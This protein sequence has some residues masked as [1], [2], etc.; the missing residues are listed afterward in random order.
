MLSVN[1]SHAKR[2]EHIKKKAEYLDTDKF[3]EMTFVRKKI[4]AKTTTEGVMT[5][6]LTMHGVAKEM[7]FVF[8]VLG[9]GQDP[10]GGNRAGFEAHTALK[11][12]DFGFAWPLKKDAPVGDDIEITLFIEGV[13]LPP[14]SPL[15]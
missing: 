9:F 15:K 8:K 4:E 12:S 5:G 13:K 14:E 10:W 3:A 2:D 6:I 1:S 7:T 11:S